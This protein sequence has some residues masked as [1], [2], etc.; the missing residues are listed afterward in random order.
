MP[1]AVS[2]ADDSIQFNFT[3]VKHKCHH[4]RAPPARFCDSNKNTKKFI[5]RVHNHSCLGHSQLVCVPAHTCGVFREQPWMHD[6]ECTTK[7]DGR[8]LSHF[9][10]I[11]IRLPNTVTFTGDTRNPSVRPETTQIWKPGLQRDAH[12]RDQLTRSI[13]ITICFVPKEIIYLRIWMIWS[14]FGPM[15]VQRLFW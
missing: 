14:W 11:Q 3:C 8:K 12:N 13:R 6:P 15:E 2:T 4:K 1:S 10:H 9:F 7:T 5:L